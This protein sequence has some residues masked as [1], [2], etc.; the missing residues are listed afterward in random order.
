MIKIIFIIFYQILFIQFKYLNIIFLINFIYFFQS[1]II[2]FNYNDFYHFAC[3]LIDSSF[4]KISKIN[5]NYFKFYLYLNHCMKL[6]D[7]L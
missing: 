7:F 5:L 6:Y 2:H 4:K 3:F 1:L